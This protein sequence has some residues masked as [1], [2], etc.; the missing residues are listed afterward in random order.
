MNLKSFVIKSQRRQFRPVV[1]P[2]HRCRVVTG[3]SVS[4]VNSHSNA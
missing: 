4:I 3:A 1:T 2:A